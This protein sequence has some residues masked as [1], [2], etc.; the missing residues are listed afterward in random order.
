MKPFSE[1]IQTYEE[2][3]ENCFLTQDQWDVVIMKYQ[4]YSEQHIADLM[5]ISKKSVIT[6]LKRTA[7]VL[8][9]KKKTV[10]YGNRP[11][12]SPVDFQTFQEIADI[13]SDGLNCITTLIGKE[14]F[15]TIKPVR[16]DEAQKFLQ[17]LNCPNI[18][19]NIVIYQEP[20]KT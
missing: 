6:C 3:K 2:Y 4:G 12:I 16:I 8:K 19:S 15:K 20:C 18:S 5:N 1:I 11:H 14:V 10:Q 9:W 17:E 13:Q 7:L